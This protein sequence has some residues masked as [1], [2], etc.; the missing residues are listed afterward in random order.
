MDN[1]IQGVI[2]VP[3]V[4]CTYLLKKNI[5]RFV[6]YRVIEGNWEY[7]NFAISLNKSKVEQF[8]DARRTYGYLTLS[9]H[10]NRLYEDMD[11]LI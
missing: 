9:N 8:I 7:R 11:S 5:L 4:H 2:Q 1:D 3:L 10:A 6:N